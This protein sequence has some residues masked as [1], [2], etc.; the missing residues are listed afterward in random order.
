MP[1]A[2]LVY[3]GTGNLNP[4]RIQ[5]IGYP[6]ELTDS[7]TTNRLYQ[8]VENWDAHLPAHAGLMQ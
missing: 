3:N 6:V 2:A 4:G 7:N 5:M 8:D 1:A